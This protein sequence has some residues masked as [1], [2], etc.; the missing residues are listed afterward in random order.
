MDDLE[1]PTN[2]FYDGK[3]ACAHSV[4]VACTEHSLLITGATLSG[5]VEWA[6]SD[7]RNVADVASEKSASF[8]GM[9]DLG[10]LNINSKDLVIRLNKLAL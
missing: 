6:Y 2:V 5:Q 8:R 3:S 1:H 7:L 4:D 10:R 9:S